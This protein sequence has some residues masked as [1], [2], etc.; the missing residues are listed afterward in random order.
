M[1]DNL[2]PSHTSKTAGEFNRAITRPGQRAFE[3]VADAAILQGAEA[4]S[5]VPPGEVTRARN[6]S[7][8]SLLSS[9]MRAAPNAVCRV[10]RC[11]VSGV[12]P[13]FARG[14]LQRLP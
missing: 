6:T 3:Q 1:Q 9:A 2:H 14:C 13:R 12:S 5:V 10:S 11:A 7:G 4:R 8:G